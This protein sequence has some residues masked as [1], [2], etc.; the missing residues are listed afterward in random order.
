MQV[1]KTA[2]SRLIWSMSTSQIPGARRI[3][4]S[5]PNSTGQSTRPSDLPPSALAKS[6]PAMCTFTTPTRKI[7]GGTR[8]VTEF[9][10]T[11]MPIVSFQ[12]AGERKTASVGQGNQRLYHYPP[13]PMITEVEELDLWIRSGVINQVKVEP[14]FGTQQCLGNISFL[15]WQ[16]YIYVFTHK[17]LKLD[18]YKSQIIIW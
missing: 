4:S 2:S 5:S 16:M 3:S 7:N 17:K 11:H 1:E 8:G 14:W 10:S 18:F 12:K 13:T 9:S 6:S 15:N